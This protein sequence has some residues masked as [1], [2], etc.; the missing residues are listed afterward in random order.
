LKQRYGSSRAKELQVAAYLLD[1]RLMRF[2]NLSERSISVCFGVLIHGMSVCTS[3]LARKKKREK[4]KGPWW[5]KEG[6]RKKR[7]KEKQ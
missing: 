1:L 2:S 7:R 3:D 5:N 6:Q 4:W